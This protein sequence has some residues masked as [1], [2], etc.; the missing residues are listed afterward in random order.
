MVKYTQTIRWHLPKNYLSVFDHFGGLALKELNSTLDS[1]VYFFHVALPDLNCGQVYNLFHPHDPMS[2]RIEPLLDK[3][4]RKIHSAPVPR[5]Q[6]FPYNDDILYN[7]SALYEN[8][9]VNHETLSMKLSSASER[10]ISSSSNARI[11]AYKEK[12]KY[13]E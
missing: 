3:S 7:Y 6:S 12:M 10:K 4:F 9:P 11:A 5:Y 13:G 1:S 8:E 2:C